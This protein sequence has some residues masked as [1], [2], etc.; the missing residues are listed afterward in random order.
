MKLARPVTLLAVG[1]IAL[2]LGGVG[3]NK[4]PQKTTNIPGYGPGITDDGSKGPIGKGNELPPGP[5][6]GPVT[7]VRTDEGIPA[8]QGHVGWAESRTEFAAQ[9][10]Y[11]DFD[12]STIKPSEVSKLEEVVRRMNTMPRKALKV[13]GHCDERGTEEYNRSLGDRRALSIREWLAGHGLSSDRIDTIS[14]GED[15]PADPGHTEA[16]WKKNRRGDL[17]LLSPP[18]SN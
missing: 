4:N 2:S 11:F 8:G 10:V 9:T 3:C 14:F 15:K 5:V 17:V 1:L 6:A 12:K 7:P 16:A 13:E 18:G